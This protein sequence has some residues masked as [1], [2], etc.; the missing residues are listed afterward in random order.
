MKLLPFGSIAGKFT[1]EAAPAA[2]ETKRKWS[3]EEAMLALRFEAKP[4][5]SAS[6]LSRSFVNGLTEK[7]EFTVYNLEAN[8]YFLEPRLPNENWYV[9]AITSPAPTSSPAGARGEERRRYFF[10]Q[11]SGL[12]LSPS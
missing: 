11:F 12:L 4:A 5:G 1:L 6:A 7:G 3:L 2:C 9:K 8:R 10:L